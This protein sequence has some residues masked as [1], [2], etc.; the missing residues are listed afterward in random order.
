MERYVS[1]SIGDLRFIDSFQFMTSSMETLVNNL[2]CEGLSHF[3]HFVNS[4][5][6]EKSDKFLL[7]K[8]TCTFTLTY[9]ITTDLRKPLTCKE[10]FYNRLK[11]EHILGKDYAFVKMYGFFF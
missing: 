9:T 1:F 3:K 5:K 10:A 2:A 8:K 6:D 11:K 7:R 4:F